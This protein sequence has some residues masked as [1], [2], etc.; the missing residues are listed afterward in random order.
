MLKLGDDVRIIDSSYGGH[1]DT[2]SAGLSG[3]HPGFY[4]LNVGVRRSFNA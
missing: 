1:D 4:C 3:A 2:H